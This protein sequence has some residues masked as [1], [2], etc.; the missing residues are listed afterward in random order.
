[1]QVRFQTLPTTA[2]AFRSM[3]EF[4]F[5][6]PFQVAA[7][8]IV[9][10]HAYP[11]NKDECYNMID[12]L[13]G[14]QK[15]SAM[16]KQFIRDRMMGKSEYIGK[17]YFSGATPENNYTP[18]VPYTVVVEESIHTYAEEGYAKVFIPT[19]GADT[20]RPVIL[21]KKGEQWFLWE[22]PGLLSDIRKPKADDP[23]A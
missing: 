15:L 6:T 12:A 3:P 18:T 10:I 14:P 2:D 8:L 7:L 23:W 4:G 9:A 5:A 21:R 19:T 20:P 17:A 11:E 1:M 13:K 16:D 22:F